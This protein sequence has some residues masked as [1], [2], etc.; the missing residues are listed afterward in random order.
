MIREDRD[1]L[2]LGCRQ[3]DRQADRQADR[4]LRQ[5]DITGESTLIFD[6]LQREEDHSRLDIVISWMFE[7][8]HLH[9]G[10]ETT[11]SEARVNQI[12]L[13]ASINMVRPSRHGI[14]EDRTVGHYTRAKCLLHSLRACSINCSFASSQGRDLT[15][16]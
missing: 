7:A 15:F 6:A 2:F 3:T 11:R 8:F 4:Q 5:F 16:H 1:V 13:K 9:D 14:K 12:F 10:R